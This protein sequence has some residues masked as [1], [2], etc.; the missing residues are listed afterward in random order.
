MTITIDIDDS[1]REQ[2]L[3]MLSHFDGDIKITTSTPIENT[4]LEESQSIFEYLDTLSQ[5]DLA[6]V[7]SESVEISL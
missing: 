3:W 4:S 1:V 7:P 5:D 6:I 2:V